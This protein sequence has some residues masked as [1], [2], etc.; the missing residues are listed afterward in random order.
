MDAIKLALKQLIPLHR[1]SS[2]SKGNDFQ[3]GKVND[4]CEDPYERGAF[5]LFTLFQETK[6]FDKMKE[7]QKTLFLLSPFILDEFYRHSIL[8]T[9]YFIPRGKRQTLLDLGAHRIP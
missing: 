3:N 4:W 1:N 9:I 2:S 6:L 8:F 5:I 7:Q